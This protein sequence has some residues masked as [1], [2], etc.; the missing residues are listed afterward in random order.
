MIAVSS[1]SIFGLDVVHRK[2]QGSLP[3]Q[4][5]LDFTVVLTS[6]LFEFRSRPELR[7]DLGIFLRRR[8]I[9]V[10]QEGDGTSPLQMALIGFY[11]PLPRL[12]RKTCL[13]F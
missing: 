5:A 8:R 4:M 13:E 7:L 12:N 10:R 9:A 1:S 3:P 11:P 6:S 2:R